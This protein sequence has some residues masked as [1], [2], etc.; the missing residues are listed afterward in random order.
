MQLCL[1]L[2]CSIAMVLV[3]GQR[4][5]L[6]SRVRMWDLWTL[7]ITYQLR[8]TRQISAGRDC[9][10]LLV[11][12]VAGLVLVREKRTRLPMSKQSGGGDR[13]R[14]VDLDHQRHRQA[15]ATEF[16]SKASSRSLSKVLTRPP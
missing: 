3:T 16:R 1:F 5:L 9:R 15:V 11:M 2:P 4:W 13:N 14:S 6:I 7:R 8:V 10:R 12:K